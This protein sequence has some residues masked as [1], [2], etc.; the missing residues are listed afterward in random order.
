MAQNVFCEV[1]VTFGR[2]ILIN[3][4][5]SHEEL[6]KKLKGHSCCWCGSLEIE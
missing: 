2:Q 1:K 6:L 3:L 4:S 5:S